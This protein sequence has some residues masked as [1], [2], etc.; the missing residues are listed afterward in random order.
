[1][2]ID[3]LLYY[4]IDREKIKKYIR[5]D[6]RTLRY[7]VYLNKTRFFKVTFNLLFLFPFVVE[8][9]IR[10]SKCFELRHK[11]HSMILGLLAYR[12]IIQY[13]KNL[14]TQSKYG[15]GLAS[16]CFAIHVKSLNLSMEIK[17]LFEFNSFMSF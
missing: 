2:Q 12:T 5:I 7:L 11:N 10:F 6:F 14:H 9:G 4:N 1:M 3:F 16:L 17:S 13:H 8:I 15:V